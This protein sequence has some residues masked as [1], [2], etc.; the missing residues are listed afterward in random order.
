MPATFQRGQRLSCRLKSDYVRDRPF[1]RAR[2]TKSFR[3]I[4]IEGRSIP[5]AWTLEEE[6]DEKLKFMRALSVINHFY[7]EREEGR[8]KRRDRACVCVNATRRNCVSGPTRSA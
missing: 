3:Q 1:D 8:E 7:E 6:N 2:G 4:K 5:H